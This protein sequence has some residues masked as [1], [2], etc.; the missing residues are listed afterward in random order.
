MKK[1]LLAVLLSFISLPAW[2]Q[3][4]GQVFAT[5]Q[6]QYKLTADFTD[7][8]AAGAQNI[9]ALAF[10]LPAGVAATYHIDCTIAY[11]QGTAASDTFAIQ[12]GTAP[13]AVMIGGVAFTNATASAAGTPSTTANT[14]SNTVVAFTPAVTTVLWARL[15][16]YVEVASNAV[17]TLVNVQ[18]SQG[19]AANVIV[20]KR[21]SG[22]TV[23]ATP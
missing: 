21:D 8:N 17:D 2:A 18:V 19:T 3:T 15:D 23:S 20:I 13:T 10:Y 5:Y 1:L 9:P 6:H 14:S 16:G 4:T 11:S 7:A 12:F 22:C